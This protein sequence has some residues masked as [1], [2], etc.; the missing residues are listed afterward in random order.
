MKHL[1]PDR[2]AALP[3]LVSLIFGIL[4]IAILP[5]MAAVDWK[6]LD[7]GQSVICGLQHRS[8]RLSEQPDRQPFRVVAR[9]NKRFLH[10]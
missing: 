4:I 7:V 9:R 8:C 2:R 6:A 1:K 10:L 3:L 5:V